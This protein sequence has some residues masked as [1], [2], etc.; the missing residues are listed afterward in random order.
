[1][2]ISRDATFSN[3]FWDSRNRVCACGCFCSVSVLSFTG[4]WY[5]MWVVAA[6]TSHRFLC[7]FYASLQVPWNSRAGKFARQWLQTDPLLSSVSHVILDE[8][9]E[10]DLHSDF[11][12]TI[13][14]N[15]IMKRLRCLMF[16]SGLTVNPDRE[17]VLFSYHKMQKKLF[18]ISCVLLTSLKKNLRVEWMVRWI[19]D[20]R[21]A[22]AI[23]RLWFLFFT[24]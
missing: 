18:F 7:R 15:I 1:M 3:T 13:I 17:I 4:L 23:F 9:H 21:N 6:W 5:L 11:L 12:I 14:K 24:I 22:Q 19:F 16:F 2:W 10:R 8:I 20:S